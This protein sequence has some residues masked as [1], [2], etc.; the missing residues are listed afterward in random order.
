MVPD[1]VSD[2]DMDPFE[3][4]RVLYERAMFGGDYESLAVAD[5]V[6]DGAEAALALSRG[7]I[8]HARL[9]RER[10]DDPAEGTLFERAASMF[11]QLGDAQGEGEALFWL[12]TY[13]QVVRGDNETALPSLERA[14]ELASG[15]GDRLTLSYVVRHLGFARMAAGDEGAARP[16][17]EESVRLRREI[18]F[19][20][21]VAAGLLALAELD[22]QAG[23]RDHAR[24]L[25]DEAAA[26]AAS[27]G[28]QG[29]LRWIE[30]ARKGL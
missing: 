5:R 26:V 10:R 21:G 16:L 19:L 23:H 1:M 27:A 6:L 9:L 7:R 4:A 15:A 18:G 24:R 22:I 3:Q 12:G 25:L 2:A 13:H 8:L 30:E 20:P 29:T 17:F 28:A 14:R 11:R